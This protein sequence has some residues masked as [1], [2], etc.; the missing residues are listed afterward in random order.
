[1]DDKWP[2][3]LP[4][5]WMVYFAVE[6]CDATAARAKALGG[7]VHVEPTDIRVGRFSIIQDPGGAVCSVIALTAEM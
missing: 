5:H 3:G 6:D 7:T 4:T 2:E 1:M